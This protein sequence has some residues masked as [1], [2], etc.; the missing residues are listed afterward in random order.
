MQRPSLLPPESSGLSRR[1]FLALGGSAAA[2]AVLLVAC[3]GD[4]STSSSA[5]T[6]A[7]ASNTTGT[8]ATDTTA[9]SDLT[10]GTPADTVFTAA[11]FAGLGAC[12]LLPDLTQGPY[13]TIE[14]I[15]RRD[16]TEG[17][18]G[19]PLRVGIQVVDE[20]CTPLPNAVVEI[21]HCDIDGDYSAYADGYRSDDAGAGTTY[22]RG[23]QVANADGIVEFHTVYPGWY[24]GRAVHIHAMVHIDDRTPLTTQFLFAD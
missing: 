18:A 8:G 5:D 13:P 11:D 17:K 4:D 22:F 6:T 3:G 24:R 14:Q 19:L 10:T 7:P 16:I 21:W 2:G 15:E 1:R 23:N 20:S 12:M 9:P